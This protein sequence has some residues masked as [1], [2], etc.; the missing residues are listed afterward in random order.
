MHEFQEHYFLRL[1]LVLQ[2]ISGALTP[3]QHKGEWEKAWRSNYTLSKMCNEITYPFPNF[4]GCN[5]EFWEKKLPH[6]SDVKWA[7]WCLKSPALWLFT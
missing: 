3:E 6:Y 7:R 1:V 5:V 2:S 4:N